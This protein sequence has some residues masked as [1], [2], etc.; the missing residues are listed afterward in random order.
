MMRPRI[1]RRLF[2]LTIVLLMSSCTAVAAREVTDAGPVV[3]PV[4]D[5]PIQPGAAVCAVDDIDST[6]SA[7]PSCARQGT[8]GFVFRDDDG[9]LYIG[10]AAHGFPDGDV[11]V[12]VP[13]CSACRGLERQ[14]F[15]H[16]VF[17]SDSVDPLH[18]GDL[19]GPDLLDFALIEIRRSWHHLVEPRVRY[20]GGP[21]GS[22]VAPEAAPGDTAAA[23]GN[24]SGNGEVPGPRGP[25][26]VIAASRTSFSTTVS[27]ASGDSGMPYL[28]AASGKALGVNANCPCGATGYYPTVEHVLDRLAARGLH[29]T[30]VTG[31]PA[32]PLADLM[33]ERV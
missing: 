2:V 1:G 6:L 25:G 5:A 27:E 9:G 23:V 3:V 29:L 14:P 18:P 10:T 13:S 30:L 12:F 33:A 19:P 8:L 16:V 31:A 4:E 15:G 26:Q 17:Q 21:V 22:I 11:E 24:G 7:A 20:W 28:H 32:P